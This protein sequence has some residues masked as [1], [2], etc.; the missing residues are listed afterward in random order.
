MDQRIMCKNCGNYERLQY[1][2]DGRYVTCPRCGAQ[3]SLY[4]DYRINEVKID[5]FLSQDEKL[6]N[7]VKLLELKQY[8]QA[9]HVF[10]EL[11]QEKSADYRSWFGLARAET[12]DFTGDGSIPFNLH[13]LDNAEYTAAGNPEGMQIVAEAKQYYLYLYQIYT[14]KNTALEAIKE[15]QQAY[16]KYDFNKE[17]INEVYKYNI[18]DQEH[19]GIKGF[20]FF[21]ITLPLAYI[22]YNFFMDYKYN[23]VEHH[24]DSIELPLGGWGVPISFI[25]M[26]AAGALAFVSLIT[27]PGSIQAFVHWRRRKKYNRICDR[28]RKKVTKA[29]NH[30]QLETERFSEQQNQQIQEI[31]QQFAQLM[32]R[33][34]Q[35]IT[36][37]NQIMLAQNQRM[38]QPDQR[39]TVY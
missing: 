32:N 35:M 31:D 26:V 10:W 14:N 5:G 39:N 3:T 20:P 25:A 27:I 2:S 12:C 15:K 18:G 29:K 11:T 21:I 16:E 28:A 7:G 19:V 13:A 33:K 22:A 24:V 38:N 1:S 9:Q 17:Q 34:N 23:V 4:S 37:W 30:L 8:K 6:Y 36:R